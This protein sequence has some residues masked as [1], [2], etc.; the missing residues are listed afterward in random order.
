ML[1]KAMQSLNSQTC[2]L[3]FLAPSINKGD[4]FICQGCGGIFRAKKS[5]P[6][7]SAERTRY[8]THNND[9]HDTRYQQFVDPITQAV[10]REYSPQ[11]QGLDFG[12][13]TG[14]VISHLLQKQDYQLRQY[15]P[16]FHNHPELLNFTYDYIVCCEVIEHFHHPDR[17]FRLLKKLLK[18][19]GCLFCMTH[20]YEPGID[21]ENWY[22]KNDFTH[23]FIFQRKTLHWI[24]RHYRFSS[25][26]I[27]DRLIRLY[28]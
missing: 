22:Y 18:P 14:P 8:E 11:H 15:D 28:A 13:G 20:L 4:F 17:E 7:P 25:V 6:T 10:I 3:C 2:P 24:E 23:V 27:N 1:P 5:H 9:V 16:F 12:A 21:F 19:G 26:Q